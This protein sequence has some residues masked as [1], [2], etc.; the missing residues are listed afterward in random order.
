MG[1]RPDSRLARFHVRPVH[2]T[3]RQQDGCERSDSDTGKPDPSSPA[4]PCPGVPLEGSGYFGGSWR[5]PACDVQRRSYRV[6]V[7]AEGVESSIDVV[8]HP[9]SRAVHNSSDLCVRDALEVAEHQHRTLEFRQLVEG[10]DDGAKFLGHAFH[11]ALDSRTWRLPGLQESLHGELAQVGRRVDQRRPALA[12]GKEHGSSQIGW[13]STERRAPAE[14]VRQL[15]G[16]H[17]PRLGAYLG[18]L[19]AHRALCLIAR[20]ARGHVAHRSSDRRARL[21]TLAACE[22]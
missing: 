20:S 4:R 15:V 17:Q 22:G 7:A 13:I 1:E 12:R 6:G 2:S 8:A 9:G 5:M 14:Q 21:P 10:A 18:L 3:G 19:L 11:P 16:V